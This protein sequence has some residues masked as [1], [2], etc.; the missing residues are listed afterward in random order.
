MCLT[1]HKLLIIKYPQIFIFFYYDYRINLQS[2]NVFHLVPTKLE[3]T[4]NHSKSWMFEALNKELNPKG[5]SIISTSARSWFL[6][7]N[8]RILRELNASLSEHSL[9]SIPLVIDLC[10]LESS[11]C[12]VEQSVNKS[13]VS[14]TS[15]KTLSIKSIMISPSTTSE[16]VDNDNAFPSSH[17]L[18][19]MSIRDCTSVS[20]YFVR[21]NFDRWGLLPYCHADEK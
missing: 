20:C 14:N 21:E 6:R 1:Q 9:P 12:N 4:G 16:R 15:F 17:K 7:K 8:L 5:Y 19:L 3:Y 2:N 13:S 11:G 10:S 18:S